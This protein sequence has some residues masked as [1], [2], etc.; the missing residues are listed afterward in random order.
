GAD[1]STLG[2]AALTVVA[3]GFLVPENN[4]DGDAF[5]LF[6]ATA[7]GG[8]LFELPAEDLPTSVFERLSRNSF[9]ARI[10]PNPAS[11]YLSIA[12]EMEQ[13]GEV[14]VE[15]FNITGQKIMQSELGQKTNGTNVETISLEGIE[16]GIY[17][18]RMTAGDSMHTSKIKV[19]N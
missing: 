8:N 1:L 3:S 10:Y 17:T 2:D 13:S 4:S 11:N 9:D 7:A 6:V 19:A 14:T 18:I 12:Y 5:G 15:I 16:N